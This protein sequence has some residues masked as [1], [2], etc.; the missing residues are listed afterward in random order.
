MCLVNVS[1]VCFLKVKFLKGFF[2]PGKVLSWFGASEECQLFLLLQLQREKASILDIC[3]AIHSP[4][5]HVAIDIVCVCRAGTYAYVS[6]AW[7]KHTCPGMHILVRG[8]RQVLGLILHLFDIRTVVDSF[9]H[10]D[11]WPLSSQTVCLSF[12]LTTGAL[13]L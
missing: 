3:K 1:S 9:M 2:T 5:G 7:G 13:G 8:Q 10:Q 6:E 12:H 4:W 11:I